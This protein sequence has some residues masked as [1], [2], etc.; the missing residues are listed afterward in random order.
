LVRTIGI[1]A[2]PSAFTF[3]IFDSEEDRVVNV[4]SIL[5]PEALDVPESLR[6][7]RNTVLDL[8]REY[9]VTRGCIRETES[10]AQ[11]PN[12]RRIQIEGVIQESFASSS[13][14]A[15]FV[16][17]ISS[18]SARVGIERSDF[19]ILVSGEKAFPRI[20]NWATFDAE[21]REAILAAVGAISA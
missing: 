8:L 9:R 5:I 10:S 20:S 11:S 7:V 1:R 17:Q 14:K 2:R 13:L 16:G 15:Y 21:E 12:V 3:A 6:Y 4:E 18:I 19:K